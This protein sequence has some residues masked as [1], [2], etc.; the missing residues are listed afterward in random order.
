MV[1]G[2]GGGVGAGG[3]QKRDCE[4]EMSRT[5]ILLASP[6]CLQVLVLTAQIGDYRGKD[7]RWVGK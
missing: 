7:D 6:C 5:G 1:A 3:L 2:G 4:A